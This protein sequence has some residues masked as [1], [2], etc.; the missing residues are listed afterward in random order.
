[1]LRDVFFEF[2]PMSLFG[3]EGRGSSVGVS[4]G[5]KLE[6][7]IYREVVGFQIWE[8]APFACGR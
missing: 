1:V 8:G 6:I 5:S 4:N 7:D 2:I 3:V